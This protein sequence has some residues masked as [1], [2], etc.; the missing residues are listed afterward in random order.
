MMALSKILLRQFFYEGCSLISIADV[1][2]PDVILACF[3]TD[4]T[5][6]LRFVRR[7]LLFFVEI[8]IDGGRT[9]KTAPVRDRDFMYSSA[10]VSSDFITQLSDSVRPLP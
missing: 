4:V 8:T 5:Q 9:N 7:R 6:H 10:D 2:I 1:L 3:D